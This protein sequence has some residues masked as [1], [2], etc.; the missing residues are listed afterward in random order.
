MPWPGPPDPRIAGY[1]PGGTIYK[2]RYSPNGIHYLTRP[3]ALEEQQR[4]IAAAAWL[5]EEERKRRIE[6]KNG[7]SP[8]TY[9]MPEKASIIGSATPDGAAHRAKRPNY[10]NNSAL[11]K[12]GA[13]SKSSKV[14]DAVIK[15]PKKP[16]KE[17]PL[18]SSDVSREVPK[19]QASQSLPSLLP[20]LL[21][22]SPT[23][24]TLSL[25]FKSL[26]FY[27]SGKGLTPK[28]QRQYRTNFS[29]SSARYINFEINLHNHNRQ[30]GQ[31]YNVVWR[32]YKTDGILQWENQDDF[33]VKSSWAWCWFS[34]GYGWADPGHWKP[35]I[36][37]VVI[38]IDG[39]EFPEE[40][41]KIK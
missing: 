29:K 12:S 5:A 16:P 22:T 24:S 36:Y 38:L 20:S 17:K 31:V 39:V 35:G 7:S 18:R 19:V 4:E 11:D 37:R 32:Y 14:A 41:F 9:Y 1:G 26:E 30:R 23:K 28:E 27:E 8:S 33:I 40:F 34:R 10:P 21:A 15:T 2:S 3:E 13:Y 6:E 25:K